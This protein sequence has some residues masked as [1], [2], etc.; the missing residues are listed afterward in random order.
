MLARNPSI[1]GA[2][3]FCVERSTVA[4]CGIGSLV[5]QILGRARDPVVAASWAG[6]PPIRRSRITT[7][8]NKMARLPERIPGKWD[9]G[10]SSRGRQPFYHLVLIREGKTARIT[11]LTPPLAVPPPTGSRLKFLERLRAIRMLGETISTT[12]GI[13][14][15]E[16]WYHPADLTDAQGES[17]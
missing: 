14:F 16:Q 1:L 9:A 17:C 8:R 4:E 12:L 2:R 15:E 11:E 6:P 5:G 10:G 13:P 3:F 7:G